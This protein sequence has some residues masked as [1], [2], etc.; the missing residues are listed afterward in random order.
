[1]EPHC[2][3]RHAAQRLRAIR[4]RRSLAIWRS[5]P[6]PAC[7]ILASRTRF[8]CVPRGTAPSRERFLIDGARELLQ[9]LR[10]HVPL[11]ELFLCVAVLQIARGP[12][13]RFASGSRSKPTS[14]TCPLKCFRNGVWPKARRRAGRGRNAPPHACG[15]RAREAGLIAVLGRPREAGQR[16]SGAAQSPMAPE[17]AAVI[18]AQPRTDLYNPNCIRSSLGT[19]F[20]MPVCSATHSR[21]ARLA[22]PPGRRNSMPPGWTRKRPYTEADLRRPAAVVLGNEAGGLSRGL[23]DGRRHCHQAADAWH[24]RQP[25]RVG[26]LGRLVLRSPATTPASRARL[27][28]PTCD[29]T[30]FERRRSSQKSLPSWSDR[31]PRPAAVSRSSTSTRYSKTRSRDDRSSSVMRSPP[32]RQVRPGGVGG[33]VRCSSE[34]VQTPRPNSRHSRRPRSPL[35][36]QR[37]R[38]CRCRSW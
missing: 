3:H 19:V 11:V 36:A 16:G 21:G 38:R 28:V 18:V 20:T 31:R 32:L 14:G 17:C 6:S 37:G 23:A 35:G 22:A 24:G 4:L 25:E 12:A 5:K 26:R 1:M 13:G 29:G 27:T 10:G 7:T 2:R 33:P 30:Q 9:A 15:T 34:P 8:A